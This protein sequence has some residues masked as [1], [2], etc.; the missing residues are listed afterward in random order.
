[1]ELRELPSSPLQDLCFW[2]SVQYQVYENQDA[3]VLGPMGPSFMSKMCPHYTLSYNVTNG[4]YILPFL[5]SKWR[6]RAH[7]LLLLPLLHS[8]NEATKHRRYSEVNRYIALSTEALLKG[9]RS[10]VE[11]RSQFH[12]LPHHQWRKSIRKPPDR[13][14]V[15]LQPVW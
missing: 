11:V 1:M 5:K 10:F 9:T 2:R 8:P 7:T 12:D 14:Q 4:K 15:I 13:K 6:H 3:T